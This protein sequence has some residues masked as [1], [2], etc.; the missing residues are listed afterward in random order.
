MA[1]WQ[2]AI[3]SIALEALDG[4]NIDGRIARL[5]RWTKIN[6]HTIAIEVDTMIDLLRD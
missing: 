4:E 6:A 2:E 1:N 3:R 5:A